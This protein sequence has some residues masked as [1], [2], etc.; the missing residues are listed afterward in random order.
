[1]RPA[2]VDIGLLEMSSAAAKA[3][4]VSGGCSFWAFVLHNLVPVTLGNFVGGGVFLGLVQWATYET[5]GYS[6]LGQVM[7]DVETAAGQPARLQGS[8]NRAAGGKAR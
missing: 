6:P 3:C 7:D 4:T 8:L 2:D 1:V 5:H